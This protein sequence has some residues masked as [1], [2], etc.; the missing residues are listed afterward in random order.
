MQGDAYKS[1]QHSQMGGKKVTR[2]VFIKNGKGS[3]S[4]CIHKNGK[5]CHSK[6]KKLTHNEMYLI[7]MGKFIPG[8]FL[9]ISAKSNTRSRTHKYKKH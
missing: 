8:L 5:K 9:D 1:V 2:K 7:K 3:K 4:I 6:T